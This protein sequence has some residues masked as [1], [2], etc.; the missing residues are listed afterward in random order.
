MV[1]INSK[2]SK[3]TPVDNDILLIL[4]S[5]VLV[6]G[7]PTVKNITYKNFV[8][9]L[10][11]ITAPVLSV[12]G[13]IGEVVIPE[14][15]IYT[16]GD[17]I[18]IRDEEDPDYDRIIH[19]NETT[20]EICANT[21]ELMKFLIPYMRYTYVVDENNIPVVDENGDFIVDIDY[22]E[23]RYWLFAILN[24]LNGGTVGQVLIKNSSDDLDFSW[25]DIPIQPNYQSD[26]TE[27]DIYSD[28]YIANKPINTNSFS[29][30][31]EFPEDYTNPPEPSEL[32]ENTSKKVRIRKFKHTSNDDVV[33]DWATPHDMDTRQP[34]QFR[35]KGIKTEA[36]GGEGEESRSVKFGMAGYASRD[37]ELSE[38]PSFG[39]P[40]TVTKDIGSGIIPQHTVYITDWS[41]DL[42]I[43]NISNDSINQFWFYRD[44]TVDNNYLHS[45][46]VI[47][48]EIKYT[49]R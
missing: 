11:L 44:I 41:D 43:P 45:I 23:V 17:N 27:D 24:V 31:I 8:D 46:A 5:E 39:T 32:Y 29:V 42:N 15:A 38:Q 6:E 14:G 12:N 33:F 49:K 3:P 2:T 47:E 48:I 25:S 26:W 9:S 30:P 20:N 19:V 10:S 13:M 16:S 37:L 40:K 28:S 36:N 22:D 4:D 21:Y 1:K 7:N 34:I 35:V 18:E